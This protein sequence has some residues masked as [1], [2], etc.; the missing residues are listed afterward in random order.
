[1]QVTIPKLKCLRCGH[2]WWPRK[3]EVRL[4]P[5]CKSAYWNRPRKSKQST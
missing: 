2:K 3:E 4:C 1:M 5:H